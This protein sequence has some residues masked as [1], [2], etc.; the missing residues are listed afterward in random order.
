MP[1]CYEQFELHQENALDANE[2]DEQVHLA[3][4]IAARCSEARLI[5]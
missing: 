2:R 1:G 3:N 5:D 4:A